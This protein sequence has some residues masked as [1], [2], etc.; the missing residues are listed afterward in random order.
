LNL[1][2]LDGSLPSVAEIWRRLRLI[3]PE[4]VDERGWA[5]REMA[6]KTIFVLLYGYAVEGRDRWIRPTAV[7][8]MTD[9]Q[10]ASFEPE[11][12]TGWLE[13]A[14]GAR[15][16]RELPGRWYGEGTREPI[17]D[18]TLRKL[19]ELGA[20][21]ERPGLPTTSSKPR[22]A[23][24]PTFADLFAPEASAEHLD[25]AITKW[26]EANLSA[27]ALA[28]LILV[29]GGAGPSPEGVLVHFPNGEI[30][31]IAQGPSA[32]LTKA[33]VEEFAPRFLGSPA[34]ILLSESAQKLTYTDEAVARAI[35]FRIQVSGVLPDVILADLD[36]KSPLIVFVEC[37]ATDGAVTQRRRAE[38][39]SLAAEAGFPPADCAHLTVFLDRAS[40]PF[41]RI[42][43]SLA[44]RSFAW[45]ATEPD[46]ILFFRE[47]QEERS[48]R[49]AALLRS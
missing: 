46:H 31:R 24:S 27:T 32:L 44:W 43:A 7:T 36:G 11:V 4:Q 12:R 23:L 34:V 29:R 35:G 5:R 25:A 22:Y 17:R 42:A 8:D 28:R 40:S 6:A 9:S 19:L 39:E 2:W 33:A 15:R 48:S 49:L 26:Q 38:L 13:R 20:V 14:Q 21:V 30:R 45:F 3:I 18:E 1:E 10:A 41:A 47:G 37:V 16:P